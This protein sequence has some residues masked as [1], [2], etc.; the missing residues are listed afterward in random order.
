V[1]GEALEVKATNGPQFAAA[2]SSAL[3]TISD[4][5]GPLG[6]AS[7]LIVGASQAAAPRRTGNM[8][9]SITARAQGRNRLRVTVAT[10]YAAAIHWGWPAH[11]IRRQPWIVATFNR[12]QSWQ[13]RMTDQ[14]QSDLDAAAAKT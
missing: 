8:A 12:D 11:G 13:D 14:V 6:A 5:T 1:T 2:L 4:M 3:G 9:G 7:P 10:P